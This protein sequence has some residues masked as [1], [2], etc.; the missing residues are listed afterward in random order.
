MIAEPELLTLAANNLAGIGSALEE[1]NLA[2]AAS[3]TR[4]LA[5]ALDEVSR[6]ATALFSRHAQTYQ[7]FSAQASEFH[8]QFVRTLATSAGQYKSTETINALGAA[9][10]TNSASAMNAAVQTLLSASE[11]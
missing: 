7:T 3:T 1:A 11:Q 5:P 8:A 2:A 9:A 10:A 6:I 4:V